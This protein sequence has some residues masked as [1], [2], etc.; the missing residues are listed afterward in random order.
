MKKYFKKYK[1]QKGYAILFTIVV[2]SAVSV[3]TAGLTNSTYK[4]L[5]LSSLANDSQTAFYQADTASD[6]ALYA[7]RV[8]VSQDP[9]FVT[10]SVGVAWTCGGENLTVKKVETGY[11]IYPTQ[12]A[13]TSGDPCFRI[14]VTKVPGVN[15]NGDAITET[16]IKAKGYNMCDITL[17]R[18][19]E[20]EIEIIYQV[21]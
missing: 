17:S 19:V 11:S 3:I 9:N 7:D 4:Q 13:D 20:R 21:Q 18:T 1:N 15:E 16:T 5:V 10:D 2:V 14:D 12:P 6:C 8:K